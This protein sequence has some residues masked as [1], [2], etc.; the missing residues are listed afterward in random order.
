MA[1]RAAARVAPRAAHA[2]R[3]SAQAHLTR[4]CA[5]AA[6]LFPAIMAHQMWRR[7]YQLKQRQAARRVSKS[8]R[9]D[10]RHRQYEKS[11]KMKNNRR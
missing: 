8:E 10:Q 7:Q 9:K 2:L 3:S 11:A 1:Y 5:C 6:A 4:A